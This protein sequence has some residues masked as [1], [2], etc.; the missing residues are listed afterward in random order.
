MKK[1]FNVDFE[2]LREARTACGAST[3]TET[4]RRGLEALIR[5]ASYTRLRTF[6]GSEPDAKDIPRRQEPASRSRM[7]FRRSNRSQSA[8][9]AA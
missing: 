2:L 8:R 7:N 5:H 3:D 4:L 6:L 1:T 9:R